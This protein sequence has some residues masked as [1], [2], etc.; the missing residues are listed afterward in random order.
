[1]VEEE[2]YALIPFYSSDEIIH[3]MLIYEPGNDKRIPGMAEPGGLLSMGS[4]RLG[5]DW[6]DL[7]AAAA[8]MT[9]ENSHFIAVDLWVENLGIETILILEGRRVS[10]W[11]TI[12]TYLLRRM[13]SITSARLH[14]TLITWVRIYQKVWDSFSFV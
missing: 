2:I 9:R 7:A 3:L 11:F 6:S 10:I 5:H 8:A 1:M 4:H 14:V 12:P 13:S